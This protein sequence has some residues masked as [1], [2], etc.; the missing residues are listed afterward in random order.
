MSNDIWIYGE[1]SNGRLAENT[2]DILSK[3]SS[4]GRTSL[5]LLGREADRV[6]DEACEAGAS[7]IIVD[8]DPRY[9]E[10][11]AEPHARTLYRLIDQG[12]PPRIML[13]TFD[14]PSRDIASRLASKLGTGALSNVLDVS[15][16]DGLTVAA[17]QWGWSY[18]AKCRLKGKNPHILLIRQGA[19]SDHSLKMANANNVGGITR[20]ISMFEPDETFPRVIRSTVERKPGPTLTNAR[21][22]IAGGR[23]MGSADNFRLIEELVAMLDGAIGTTRAAVD[24]GWRPY[25][26]QI[27][28]TG[29]SIRPDVY[30]ACGISG[31]V[32]HMKG[33]RGSKSIIAINKD[34]DAPIMRMAD[35]GIVGDAVE[36]LRL[37]RE[38][39]QERLGR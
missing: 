18:T 8:A 1:H 5:I 38:K 32:H 37:L 39:L 28:Q 35:V 31:A 12:T 13:F 3:A 7:E 30:I 19:F 14:P 9:D 4:M 6:V 25:T 36:L 33:V 24:A 15:E 26:E 29:A 11:L 10:Y 22:V 27:G 17:V 23:G 2:R 16:E 20:Y 34:P 21:L